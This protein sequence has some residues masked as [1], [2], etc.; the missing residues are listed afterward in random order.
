LFAGT[1]A[2]GLEAISRGA[3][4]VCFVDRDPR[5]IKVIEKNLT[6]ANW[7]DRA[8][9]ARGNLLGALSWISY[10]AGVDQFE[11]IFMGPPYRDRENRPLAYGNTVLS[12]LVVANLLAPNG[13]II[14]QHHQRE[15]PGAV[16]GLT[17]FRQERYGDSRMTFYRRSQ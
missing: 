11:L 17:R 4:R 10:R 16:K 1:G 12:N 7:S 9:V 8:V 5:C 13:W 2:V 15:N 14:V 6:R 3:Q